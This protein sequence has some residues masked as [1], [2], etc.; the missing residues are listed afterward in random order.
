[1]LGLP[2]DT[3]IRLFVWMAIGLAIYFRYG[4]KH[5]IT[6]GVK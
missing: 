3:W 6:H 5:S 1:M 4:R 2:G